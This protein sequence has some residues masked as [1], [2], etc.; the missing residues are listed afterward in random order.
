MTYEIRY[1]TNDDG[2]TIARGIADKKT[3]IDMAKSIDR[4]DY[5]NARIQVWGIA[6]DGTEDTSPV[7][8]E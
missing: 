4:E 3:A 5:D 7:Y 8:D 6:A 2:G 1:I